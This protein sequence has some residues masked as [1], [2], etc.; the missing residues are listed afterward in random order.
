MSVFGTGIPVITSSLG[1]VYLEESK[2][3]Y[4]FFG[5]DVVEH[6][7]VITGH[8]S[9]PYSRNKSEFE[10][11]VLLCN[12]SGVNESSSVAKFIDILKYKN[13]YFN[14]IPHSDWSASL[15]VYQQPIEYFITEFVPYYLNNDERYDGIILK[16]EARKN[17]V[18][19]VKQPTGYGT[20]YGLDWGYTGF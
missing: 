13:Q 10:V 15:D 19:K 8:K 9:Y 7:S 2:I 4:Q 12:Y 16:L 14:F 11:D 20:M 5:A 1:A 6:Q 17:S 3:N 18:I